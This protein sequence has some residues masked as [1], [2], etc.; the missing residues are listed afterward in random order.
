MKSTGEVM[1]VHEDFSVALYKALIAAGHVF[2]R[3]GTILATIA[4]RD[5]E[6]AVPIFKGLA[7][8]G[9]KLI[10]TAGTA[11][12]LNEAGLD[13]ER[14]NK[15]HEGSPHIVDLIRQNEIQLVINTLT[16]G[17]NPERDGF[18]IRRAAVEHGV[19]CLTSLDI[20]WVL[21]EVVYAIKEGE[22]LELVPLQEYLQV[23]QGTV[24]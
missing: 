14:V 22:D 12:V 24:P 3:N 11:Q 16:R 23:S 18:Q 8:L 15:V 1:G 10:A 21:M 4:D 20:A 19:P 9:Y 7:D 5:K 13:V 2:P 6:E 17:K